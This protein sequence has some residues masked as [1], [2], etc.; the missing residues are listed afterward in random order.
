MGNAIP[1]PTCHLIADDNISCIDKDICYFVDEQCRDKVEF[2][3][4]SEIPINTIKCSIYPDTTKSNNYILYCINQ[5]ESK[6]IAIK[7]IQLTNCNSLYRSNCNKLIPLNIQNNEFSIKPYIQTFNTLD[8]ELTRRINLTLE[9]V[10]LVKN[11]NNKITIIDIYDVAINV[12]VEM[13]DE[14]NFEQSLSINKDIFNQN[15][16]NINKTSVNLDTLGLTSKMIS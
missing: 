16:A 10:N 9:D 7:S 11:N 5:S 13:Y 3:K 4:I 8:G 15:I 2:R 6:N 12:N 14:S 1:K